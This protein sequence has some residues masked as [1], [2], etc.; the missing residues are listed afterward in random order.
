MTEL[1]RGH[2]HDH[3]HGHRHGAHVHPH[4]HDTSGDEKRLMAALVL[5]GGFMIAEFAGGLWTHSLALLADSGHMLNDT[6]ALGLALIALRMSRRPA[7][8]KRSYGYGRLQIVTAFANAIILIVITLFISAEA[9]MRLFAPPHILSQ[10]MLII[11]SLGLLVNLL[12]VFLL[13]RSDKHN[14]NIRSALT[15]VLGDLLGSIAAIL[16]AALILV[17][18]WAIADPI[19]SLFVVAMIATSA[20]GVLYESAHILLE[21]TPRDINPDT[22]S[23]ALRAEISAILD[24]HHVHI[25]SLDSNESVITLH[26]V[27]REGSDHESVLAAVQSQLSNRFGL[28]HATIQIESEVCPNPKRVGVLRG[29][30]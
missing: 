4:L 25:W 12:C 16:A 1:L 22:V 26:L 19:L 15:H 8:T 20:W 6:I 9:V 24:I 14:L 7:D 11:A 28:N 29:R 30:C 5:T 17:F 18:G 21:G 13:G 2:R 23:A 3:T 10:P 27:L